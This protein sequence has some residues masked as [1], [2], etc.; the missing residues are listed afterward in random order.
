LDG[1][2]V[3]LEPLR[4]AHAG[5]LSEA[6]ERTDWQWFLTP[7]RSRKDV[8]DRI[9]EGLFSEKRGDAYAFAVVD[10]KDGKVI[11]STSYLAVVERYKRSEIGSTWYAKEYWGTAVNPEC[12]YLLLKHAFEDWGAVRIQLITDVNNLHSQRAIEKLGAKLEGV[13]RNH[14]IKSDGSPRQA[15][16]YSIVQ[17]EWPEVRDKLNSRLANF[18]PQGRKTSES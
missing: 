13:L 14:G 7:L 6:A 2:F 5:P 17:S 11:G 9:A 12:K 10:K 15:V 16:Q 4:E 18:S 3:R 8:E 1:R